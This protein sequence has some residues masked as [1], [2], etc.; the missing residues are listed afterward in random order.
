MQALLRGVSTWFALAAALIG[1]AVACVSVWSIAGRQL[2]GR[3]VLG[4]VEIT[5]VG[6]ALCISL[7]LPWCQWQRGQIIVDFFTQRLSDRLRRSLDAA[8]S[9]LI[10]S[11]CL[12]L[13]WR[14][15]V[16]ALASH[17]AFEQTMILGLPLWWA[18]AGL[19]PGLALAALVG[20]WQAGMLLAGRPLPEVFSPDGPVAPGG[21]APGGA[22]SP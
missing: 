16:G 10:A 18:Y 17:Q 19:A 9:V 4:D 20:L 14:T 12:L 3:P 2:L 6:I 22:P 7:C 5:Q 1:L 11:M 15:V 13:A 21:A 8:G